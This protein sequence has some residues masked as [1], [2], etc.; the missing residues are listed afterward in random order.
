M[1]L[2][3]SWQESVM[4]VFYTTLA[5]ALV[6]VFMMFLNSEGYVRNVVYALGYGWS[7]N[8]LNL[9]FCRWFPKMH[10]ITVAALSLIFG[11]A[12]GT[13]LILVQLYLRFG[14]DLFT[15]PGLLFGNF[16]FGFIISCVIFYL[17]Y[18]HN[19]VQMAKIALQEE[20]LQRLENERNLKV[21]ELKV[22]QSQ[23]EPHFLFNTLAN[24]QT[25]ID[26][27]PE[28]AKET[29]ANLT[30]MLRIALKRTRE[31]DIHLGEE[32]DLV[33]RYLAIQKVR[34]GDRLSFLIECP[35]ALR[36]Q[37]LPP[38][39]IQPLVENAI[40]HGLEPRHEPGKIE[41]IVA[42][43]QDNLVIQV[44]DNGAGLQSN[45]KGHGIGVENIRQRL[46]MQYGDQGYLDIQSRDS[47]GVESRL[48]IPKETE[49]QKN[50]AQEQMS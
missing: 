3:E 26:I 23:I 10:Q 38:L 33:Q 39:L 11:A 21:A 43:D 4:D 46:A 17:F 45:N 2:R 25:L 5:C 31:S 48:V 7:I 12:I 49:G 1:R 36:Q 34:M 18:S 32:L 22:V 28:Q 29:L 14:E 41:L 6:A 15:E 8:V 50:A 30:H 40:V 44:R 9:V 47:G 35:E 24:V 20:T 37:H 13:G 16:A 42:V 19:R 27:E